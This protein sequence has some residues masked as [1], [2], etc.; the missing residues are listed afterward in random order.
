MGISL[1]GSQKI[2]K[3][4]RKPFDMARWAK[5]DIALWLSYEGE[6]YSGLA[7]QRHVEGVKT[8]EKVLF[9]ALIKC[10]L[11]ESRD[12]CHYS[13]CGRTDRGVS[14]QCQVVGLRVRSVLRADDELVVDGMVPRLAHPSD[15]L[16]PGIRE[17]DYCETL[18]RVLPSDVRAMAWRSVAPEFSAR[19]SA[20]SRTY[21]YFFYQA[22]PRTA[23]SYNLDRMRQ[24]AAK[25]VGEHDFRNLC[26]MDVEHVKNY[27]RVVYDASVDT[28]GVDEVF[29]FQITGQA[30]LWH[31]VRCCVAVLLLVAQ[32]LE[33]PDVVDV[34]LDVENETRRRPH[35]QPAPE[36]PLVL[37]ECSFDSLAPASTPEALARLTE[38][39]E[40]R[41]E[42]ALILSAKRRNALDY[43]LGLEVRRQDLDD[44]L[45][46]ERSDPTDSRLKW[47]DAFVRSK[48]SQLL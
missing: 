43:I 42:E 48:F 45:G 18:N 22:A 20:A 35:Y 27:R 44:Y 8:V 7:E 38:H 17:L 5:R 47:A 6:G 24:A 23:G 41:L 21:R 28:S 15:E 34:L 19:F 12:T 26:K 37:Q 3:R 16:K 29:C 1:S 25:L 39:Y 14:A 2:R 31:M 9:E 32:G 46:I 4:E 36:V 13:R 11:I 33:E 10:C 40:H 30:F